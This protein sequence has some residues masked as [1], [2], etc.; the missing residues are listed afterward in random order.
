MKTKD[1]CEKLFSH[2]DS[3]Y[4][5]KETLYTSLFGHKEMSNIFQENMY[6]HK[7]R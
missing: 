1:V 3:K 2:E 7:I 4:N 6:I 5:M